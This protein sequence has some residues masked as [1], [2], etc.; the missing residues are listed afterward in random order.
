MDRSI[1]VKN[2]TKET[3]F[4]GSKYGVKSHSLKAKLPTRCRFLFKGFAY[5]IFECEGD[6]RPAEPI[7]GLNP[8]DS[9]D[10][11]IKLAIDDKYGPSSFLHF[12]SPAPKRSSLTGLRKWDHPLIP[13]PVPP[14]QV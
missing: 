1:A 14:P 7:A 2:S 3:L 8:H 13:L 11:E 9:A 4:L 6:T 12:W 10:Q 5:Y